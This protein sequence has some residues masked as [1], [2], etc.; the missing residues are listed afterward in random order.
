MTV[1]LVFCV[2]PLERIEEEKTAITCPRGKKTSVLN[3]FYFDPPIH[4]DEYRIA[5][6]SCQ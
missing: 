2:A 1:A 6:V 4:W 3:N 5:F